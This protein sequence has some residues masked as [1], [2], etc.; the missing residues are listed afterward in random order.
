MS[1]SR[2]RRLRA[3]RRE[4]VAFRTRAAARVHID[5]LAFMARRPRWNRR[6][7][8]GVLAS[9][10]LDDEIRGAIRRSDWG[11]VQ[12]GLERAIGSRPSRFVLDPTMAAPIRAEI[13]RRWPSA[14]SDAREAADR[15]LRGQYDLLGYSGLRIATADTAIDWHLDPVSGLR[16]PRTFWA[17]VPY[18]D[19]AIGDHK[20][21]WE[22]NRHQHWL[23]LGRALW[24]TGD[25][26]YASE[27]VSQLRSWMAANP[28]LAGINWASMLELAFRCLSWL[29]ALHLLL[30]EPRGAADAAGARTPTATDSDE[31][32]LV[33]M[34]LG[35]DRQLEHVAD[36]LSTYFSPNTHLIG[37]A[38]ALYVVGL[39][40]PELRRSARWIDVGRPVLLAQLRAQVG[41]DGGHAERSFHYHRYTHDFYLLALMVAERCG[42][43]EAA[44]AFRDGVSRMA[45]FLREIADDTGRTPLVGDDDGGMLWPM[46]GRDPS[47][48]RDSLALAA[49][50]LGR[51]DLAAWGPCEETIW[52]GWSGYADRIPDGSVRHAPID[53]DVKLT[54][55]PHTGYAVARAGGDHL[56]FDAGPHGYLNCGHAHADALAV[57]LTIG[58][59]ALLVDPGTASYTVN[60]V[61]RDRMRRTANHNTLCVDGRSSSIPSGP[62]H[63]RS[64]ADGRLHEGRGN[65]GFVWLEGSH[66]GY[67]P[68][69]HRRSIVHAGDGWLFVD[70]LLGDGEADAHLHWHF[71][72]AWHLERK[73][74]AVVLAHGSDDA[75]AW[76]L[77]DAAALAPMRGD[78]ASGL[79]W[80]S[81]RYGALVRAWSVR[82]SRS[83]RAPLTMVTWIGGGTTAESVPALERLDVN[84]TNP[85]DGR[86][87]AVRVRRAETVSA[88]MLRP[89][90]GTPA[91]SHYEA[92]GYQTNA[93]MLHYTVSDGRLASL[94]V[95]ICTHAR[96]MDGGLSLASD[97]HADLHLRIAD[98]RLAIRAA[99]PPPQLRVE[100]SALEGIRE[101]TLNGR[102]AA[103]TGNGRLLTVSGADWPD[104][105]TQTGMDL[106]V[107]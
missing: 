99:C 80:Y 25:P 105:S 78:E 32:W 107:A 30:G 39:S 76:L 46:A 34:F 81:P 62:F 26:R 23:A 79:G 106:C 60:P 72:P 94:A 96:A 95:A 56:V 19:A 6:D 29:S 86:V 61:L 90:A 75:A 51:P 38:L 64:V 87:V 101:V 65:P 4:E 89:G 28:P 100:G 71:D 42:D 83:G 11:D 102:Y 1:G 43:D 59:R 63:W 21:V 48:A 68:L 55:F 12:R 9:Y 97:A 7:L 3:M 40:L 45:V 49:A 73:S 84:R 70:E 82:T 52:L 91:D 88:T 77:H 53:A 103:G 15:M 93:C 14:A 66:D 58:G 67:A 74:D 92:A 10:V 36:N 20:V 50:V 2:L 27:I 33:D 104:G 5:R 18:L 37:E 35:M 8:R 41:P 47:D 24:L 17:D 98:G 85:S 31:A 57:T 16:A 69:R 54:T 22:L 44:A 13:R